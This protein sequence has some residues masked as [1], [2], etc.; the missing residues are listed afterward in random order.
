VSDLSEKELRRIDRYVDYLL[1]KGAIDAEQVA[2]ITEHIKD[3]GGVD[4]ALRMD[5]KN[6]RTAVV[7]KRFNLDVLN[8]ANVLIYDLPVDKSQLND[9]LPALHSA[10]LQLDKK[11]KDLANKF[12]KESKAFWREHY[13]IPISH[14]SIKSEEKYSKKLIKELELGEGTGYTEVDVRDSKLETTKALTWIYNSFLVIIN[15]QYHYPI[16]NQKYSPDIIVD[17]DGAERGVIDQIQELEPL[18]KKTASKWAVA[19]RD[20]VL[21]YEQVP[22]DRKGF[23]PY[24]NEAYFQ[25]MKKTEESRKKL[26]KEMPK[27]IEAEYNREMSRRHSSDDGSIEETWAIHYTLK[28]K[29]KLAQVSDEAKKKAL[30]KYIWD[31]LNLRLR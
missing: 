5:Q 3:I 16:E 8:T 26:E 4:E 7:E 15:N 9:V 31:S 20:F 27:K 28:K 23:F 11:I 30:R 21:L 12:P 1:G 29:K 19:I 14:S 17:L 24:Q 13:S 6:D 18:S 22:D 25:L 2:H 10:G